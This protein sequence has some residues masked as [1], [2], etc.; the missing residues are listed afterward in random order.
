MTEE[1]EFKRSLHFEQLELEGR[2]WGHCPVQAEGTIHGKKF[3]FRARYEAWTFAI[4]EDETVDPVDIDFPEQGFF[5][6]ASFGNPTSNAASYMRYDNA[7]SIIKIC[8]QEYLESR[9]P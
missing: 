1:P 9:K 6:E 4:S 2:L 7:E 8:A 3:Y 5:R